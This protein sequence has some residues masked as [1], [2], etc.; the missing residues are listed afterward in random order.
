MMSS[1]IKLPKKSIS[2]AGKFMFQKQ[3]H[4]V[5]H[6]HAVDKPQEIVAKHPVQEIILRHLVHF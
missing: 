3:P 2:E 5:L 1:T 4:K 6:I